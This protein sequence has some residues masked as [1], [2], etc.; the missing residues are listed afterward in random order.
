M[1]KRSPEVVMMP[2]VAPQL[3][4]RARR[5]LRDVPA[6]DEN[7]AGTN[8]RETFAFTAAFRAATR[9]KALRAGRYAPI[10]TLRSHF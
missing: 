4:E 3:E 5:P 7:G 10:P 8:A 9:R 2:W 1:A 6:V